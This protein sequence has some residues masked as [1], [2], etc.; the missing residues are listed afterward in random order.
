MTRIAILLSGTGSLAD[1]VVR[2]GIPVHFVIA[3]RECS[4]LEKMR[5]HGIV[6]RLI[7]RK[8]LK[9]Q[10][11]S[12]ARR[13]YT[14][15]IEDAL[16]G[17]DIDL[18]AMLGFMTVLDSAIFKR[19]KGRIVNTHPSL[20]PAFKGDAAVVDALEYGV[21]WTGCTLHYATAELDAGPII[22]Q[23]PVRV[24]PHDTVATLH[25]R[26]KTQERRMIERFLRDPIA[27]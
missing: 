13:L 9:L 14:Q 24:M 16:V 18:V 12:D 7:P 5:S 2:A 4:G 20:L 8:G 27:S 3:D 22:D 6:S 21:K 15:Q 23:I 1:A 17:M 25:E 26:I 10:S 11:S 19:F